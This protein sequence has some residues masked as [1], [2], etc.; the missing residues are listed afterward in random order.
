MK[1]RST[2]ISA[3]GLGAAVILGTSLSAPAGQS[4]AFADTA[5]T[6]RLDPG[7]QFQTIDGY[8]VSMVDQLPGTSGLP[9]P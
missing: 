9:W 3:L 2:A 1:S 5:V 6:I 8:G 7:L 4:P